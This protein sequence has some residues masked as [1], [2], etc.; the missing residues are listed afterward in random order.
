MLEFAIL[1]AKKAGD[2][3]KDHAQDEI[4]VEHKGRIDLV[5]NMDHTSQ[6]MIVGEIDRTFP[7]HSIIAEEGVGKEKSSAY[8]W[9]IDPLDGTTNFVHHLPFF[10]VSIAVRRLDKPFIGVCYN[11]ISGDL[12]HA[13]VSKGAYRNGKR[14]FV[15]K[16]Q[17]L[18]DS[19]V[20]TGFPYTHEKLK[21]IMT[22]F[23]HVLGKARGIRRMGSAALDLCYV[24]A[25]SFDAFWEEGLKPWDMAAG[26]TILQEA[27]GL[28]TSLDGGSFDLYRGDILASNSLVHQEILKCM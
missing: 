5:T 3:L 15:S 7:D 24:A 1:L 20:A 6:A 12:F 22:S 27:G 8:T 19:L 26:V 13:Q 17:L 21:K 4:M 23:S 16:T 28:V 11:P 25:G 14:I 2:F 18:I 10:C 9:F